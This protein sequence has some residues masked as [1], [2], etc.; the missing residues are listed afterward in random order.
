[1]FRILILLEGP[2]MFICLQTAIASQSTGFTALRGLLSLMWAIAAIIL[3]VKAS[4]MISSERTRETLDALLSTPL[5]TREII[6]QKIAG[7]R[8]LMIVLAIPI[9][10]IHLTLLLMH[11]D[12][13]T[14]F[15]DPTIFTVGAMLLYCVMS[16]ATT[17]TVM[18]MIS[19][20]STLL[21]LRSTSQSRSFLAA[22][23][24]LA[25]WMIFSF[26]LVRPGGTVFVLL[27][28]FIE[29]VPQMTEIYRGFSFPAPGYNNPAAS[30]VACMVR[31]DGS[32]QANEAILAAASSVD[33]AYDSAYAAFSDTLGTAIVASLSVLGMH[34]LLTW[35]LRQLTVRLAPFLLKRRDEK[36]RVKSSSEIPV[37]SFRIQ[38]ESV[39]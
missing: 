23:A 29:P 14:V 13:R 10:S 34:I 18:H 9:L 6:E 11:V 37:P 25:S 8:R 39:A 22:I 19:W 31:P 27:A 32:I 28:D 15:R 4:T 21:G 3:S 24:V 38:S 26:V 7:M 1:L 2:T 35:L 12:P 16:V 20:L 36:V 5:T 17:F 30:I 33:V